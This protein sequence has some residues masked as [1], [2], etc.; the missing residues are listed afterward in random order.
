VEAVTVADSV[1]N[2]RLAVVVGE[3][4]L[5]RK[6][7]ARAVREL[8]AR[9]GAPVSCDHTSVGRWLDGMQPRARTA[10]L[11]AEVLSASAGRLVTLADIGMVGDGNKGGAATLS[12]VDTAAA[13]L[14]YAATWSESVGSSLDLWRLDTERREFLAGAAFAA[15]AHAVPVLRWL[16]G[17]APE[18]PAGTGQRLV[19]MPD[20]EAIREM[21]QGFQRIDNKF[22]GGVAR[23]AVVRY[24][25]REV[26]PLLRDGRYSASVGRALLGAT[27]ELAKLAGWMAHDLDRHGLGQRYLVQ[28]LRLAQAA[29]DEALGSEILNGMSHQA[30]YLGHGAAGV[31]LARAARKSA[32]RA[33]VPA[34]LAE[35]AV[36]EAH[37]HA[38]SGDERQTTLA[39]G[40]AERIFDRANPADAPQWISY[41]D[42]AYLSAKFGHCFRELRQPEPGRKFAL[43]SLDMDGTYV[44]GMLF[45]TVL[46]AALE[47]QAGDVDQAVATGRRALVLADGMKSVRVAQYLD[48][49]R[50]DLAPHG[51]H[52]DVQAFDVDAR[53]VARLQLA[54]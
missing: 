44:R 10:Q 20:V 25:D 5:S 14:E 34:L 36:M 32:E 47:A 3:A 29:G 2:V 53:R 46:L 30:T 16:V 39:L 18:E 51:T 9:G 19:G 6:A 23:E 11:V 31:D 26:A 12:T 52:P 13:S 1:P 49:L 50:E 33:G 40:E 22:G 17:G 35:A 54:G 38:R 42:E 27:A 7:L 37:G 15:G 8:S 28:S 24:L 43:R 48:R 41:F 4:G 45:N 21:T